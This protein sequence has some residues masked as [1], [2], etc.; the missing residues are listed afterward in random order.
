M[1]RVDAVAGCCFFVWVWVGV[2]SCSGN[3]LAVIWYFIGMKEW[4]HERDPRKVCW[5]WYGPGKNSGDE[6]SPV[7]AS[8]SLERGARRRH[9]RSR[10]GVSFVR[11]GRAM[12]VCSSFIRAAG[13]RG[14]WP[15][16]VMDR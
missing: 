8:L 11:Y 5:R 14:C 12:V 9:S 3:V 10:H 13:R 7:G 2:G 4:L 16:G 6:E 15:V 1:L